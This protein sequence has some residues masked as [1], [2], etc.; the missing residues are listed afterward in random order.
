MNFLQKRLL[1]KYVLN[2]VDALLRLTYYRCSAMQYGFASE[3]CLVWDGRYMHRLVMASGFD[4][5]ADIR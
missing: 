2:S 5:D 1:I 4:R 3:L